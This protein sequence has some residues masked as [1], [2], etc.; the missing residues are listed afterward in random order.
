MRTSLS[1]WGP[2]KTAAKVRSFA[3]V[4]FLVFVDFSALGNTVQRSM[5]ASAGAVILHV[6]L[7]T[8]ALRTS[9]PIGVAGPVATHAPAGVVG[10]RAFSAGGSCTFGAGGSC[11]FSAGGSREFGVGGSH[12]FEPWRLKVCLYVVSFLSLY[13]VSL[14]IC[15]Q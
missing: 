2:E 14:C 3:L 7:G 4:S 10:S 6:S 12:I 11:A 5:F 9:T 15:D 13:V 1:S 8:V